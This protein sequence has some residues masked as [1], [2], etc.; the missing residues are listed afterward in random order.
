M[1]NYLSVQG[2]IAYNGPAIK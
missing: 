1:N 2:A